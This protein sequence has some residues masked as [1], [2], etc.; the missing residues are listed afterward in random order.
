MRLLTIRSKIAQGALKNPMSRNIEHVDE[1]ILAAFLAGD[2]PASLRKEIVS[3]IADNDSARDLLGMAREAM[4]AADVGDGSHAS[5][6]SP[7]LALSRRQDSRNAR[8][9]PTSGVNNLWKVTA[10]FASA[11]LVLSFTVAILIFDTAPPATVVEEARWSP[12]VNTE[13]LELSWPAQTGAVI[14]QILVVDQVSGDASVLSRTDQTSFSIREETT[15]ESAFVANHQYRLWILA[16]DEDGLLL[17]RSAS[18][19]VLED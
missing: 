15:S 5:K 9:E 4:D 19:S 18:I 14:Y 17:S 6:F 2:L 3:Y 13:S 10:L 7:A 8:T 11:V 1:Y 16:F 12:S